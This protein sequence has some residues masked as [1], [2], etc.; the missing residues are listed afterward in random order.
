MLILDELSYSEEHVWVRRE[1]DST[2]TVGITDYAQSEL[3]DLIYVELP[4]EGDEIILLEPF[5]SIEC[6][7]LVTDIYAPIGGQVLEVN[8][9]VIDNPAIIS[10]APYGRGW[11]LR[12]EPADMEELRALMSADDY[13]EYILA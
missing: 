8:R 6:A 7:E 13:E 10:D 9:D 4:N 2:V 11:I 5:G 12:I 1:D 3:G